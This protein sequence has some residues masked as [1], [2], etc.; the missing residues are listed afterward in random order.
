[1][2]S[3]LHHKP[4]LL[5]LMARAAATI[6]YQI[7]GVAV[8]WQIYSLTHRAFD[9]GL[10]G[11]VQFIPSA[12]LVLLVGHVADRHD[13]RRIVSLS[14]FVEAT[15]L[16]GLCLGSHAQWAG[17]ET[18]LAFIFLIGI[19]RAF[20]FT[21]LQTLVPSLVDQETLPRAMAL[22]ASVRQAA[23]IIGPMMGGFLYIAGPAV[24]YAVSGSLFFLSAAAI[25]AVRIE[26]PISR[27]REPVSLGFV[28]AGISYIRS[29][30][31][32][33]GAISLDLFAVLLGGATAL[34]P[35][36][37]R[38]ILSAGPWGLGFLRSA[39]AVGAFAASIYLARRPLQRRV[40]KVMFA[41][42]TWFG[43]ATIAFALSTS[44]ALSFAALVVLG[45]SDMLSVVIRSTLVQLETP[46]EM[47][48]R[49]SAVNAIFIGT[50]NEL[51]EFE[52][53]VTAAWFGTVPAALIGGIGTL[54]VVLLWRRFF[55]ELAQ[56]ERLQ[57][58]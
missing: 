17:K 46:D 9:L 30:R 44:I 31:V 51:G 58:G 39:P 14:Q 54:L 21:T 41:A 13:R 18:I 19:A 48:G 43:I 15:A 27:N 8:G 57:A 47:R 7:T 50:S 45:W 36:Y 33:L 16:F 4:F 22:N 1:M 25:A 35:I 6:A 26:R 29:R 23:V 28:F 40:G 38:D 49:V 53:G 10:V 56:R 12:A 55:P 3:P 2:T 5:F 20:E 52:S 11:L 24:V 37:A 34:L 42:V 32:V